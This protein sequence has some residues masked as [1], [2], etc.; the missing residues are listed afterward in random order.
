MRNWLSNGIGPNSPKIRLA[1]RTLLCHISLALRQ[2]RAP[3]LDFLTQTLC[4]CIGTMVAWLIAIYTERGAHQ[5]I[6]NHVFGIAGAALCALA[7]S[8]IAPR[9]G[10]LGLLIAGP[11]CAV[12][13]IV[14]GHAIRRAR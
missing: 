7:V 8:L 5:L 12:L 2:P 1:D 11:P 13:A 4:L 3:P 6:W 10:I 14:A 9:L